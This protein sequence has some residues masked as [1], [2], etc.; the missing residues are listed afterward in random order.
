MVIQMPAKSFKRFEDPFDPKSKVVKYRFY[1]NVKHIPEELQNWMETNPREQ[2]MTT[3]VAKAIEGG[4]LDNNKSFHLWNRGILIS[5]EKV[6][7]DNKENTVSLELENPKI[8]GN[9]DGGHTFKKILEVRDNMRHDQYVEIEVLT[10]IDSPEQLAEARNTSNAVDTKSIEELRDSFAVIKNIIQ[11]QEIN[12]EK[13]FKRIAFKQNEHYNDDEIEK[14]IDVREL[15]AIL[16]MFSPKVYGDK[17]VHPIQSYTG[18]EASLRK[19]LKMGDANKAKDNKSYRE[20]QIRMMEDIIPDIIKLWDHIEITFPKLSKELGKRYGRKGYSNYKTDDKDNPLIVDETLFSMTSLYYSIPK[21]IMYPLVGAF[22][23]LVTLD[24]ERQK[25][26]WNVNP[27]VVWKTVG[28]NLVNIVLQSSE[29]QRDN[30]NAIGKSFNT[31]D[32]LYKEIYI[33]SLEAGR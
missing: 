25:Y 10:G 20:N 22:R 7:F 4:L 3:D 12:G 24:E 32:L 17:N 1:V 27:F 6:S 29:D 2:K 16:N 26:C 18:K 19:F 21:G 13:Y 14:I 31:W 9:I 5:C 30:P 8:H 23:A 28:K 15:I 33:A 11:D